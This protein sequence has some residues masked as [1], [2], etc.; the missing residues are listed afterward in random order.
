DFGYALTFFLGAALATLFAATFRIYLRQR[1]EIHWR[2]HLTRD[3][4]GR[5]VGEQAYWQGGVHRG[6]ND[7]PPP[8][9]S[10][11][12]PH[13]LA[14]ALGLSLS[15]LSAVVTLVSFGGILWRLS[16]RWPVHIGEIEYHVPGLMMWVAIGYALL[17]MWLTHLVGRKLVPINFDRL[18]CEA[19]FRYG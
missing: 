1:L 5:W 11:E 14:T 2:E 12:K 8:R 6:G 13:L 15:L 7:N 3:F 9:D 17:A 16:G 4:V 19:N 10:Q 18:R